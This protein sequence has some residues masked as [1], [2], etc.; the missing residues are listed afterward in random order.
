MTKPTLCLAALAAIAICPFGA[1]A[2]GGPVVLELNK[3][4]PAG[5]AGGCQAFV[6]IENGAGAMES[7]N[8]DLVM[9]DPE[10][11]I[12]RRLAV[13]LGPLRAG[14]TSVKVFR[15]DGVE[16]GRIGGVLLN[17]VIGCAPAPEAGDCFAL[18]STRARGAVAF[19]E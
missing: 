6:L 4:E 15:V 2:A 14:K 8:V 18:V 10:G 17:D 9:M 7:L 1:A 16:C 11:V 3:L 5:E 19:Y 12:A 13:E